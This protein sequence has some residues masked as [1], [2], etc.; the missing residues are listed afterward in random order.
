MDLPY[1]L[2]LL[3]A[4]DEQPYGFIKLRGVRADYLVRMLAEVG[5]VEA[6]LSDGQPGSFTAINRLTDLGET[7]LRAFS[8]RSI[9]APVPVTPEPHSANKWQPDPSV[10]VI[11]KWKMNFAADLPRLGQG[12]AW[13]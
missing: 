11:D 12:A 9:S 4:A 2:K 5:L 8:D 1:A 7:F 10:T 6:T 3:I 13:A